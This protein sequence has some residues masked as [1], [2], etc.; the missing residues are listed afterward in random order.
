M[1]KKA[2]HNKINQPAALANLPP[3]LLP[4]Y[5]NAVQFERVCVLSLLL[6]TVGFS[7]TPSEGGDALYNYQNSNAGLISLHEAGSKPDL[8]THTGTRPS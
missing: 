5:A 4:N 2:N 8:Q 3:R 6:W 1:N 7:T